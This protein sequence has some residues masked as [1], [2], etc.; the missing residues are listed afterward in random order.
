MAESNPWLIDH[1]RR[2]AAE[3]QQEQGEYSAGAAA[4]T[5]SVA[6]AKGLGAVEVARPAA[7]PSRAVPATET[8]EWAREAAQ[9]A[10]RRSAQKP[11]P[12][13]SGGV[14]TRPSA[15]VADAIKSRMEQFVNDTVMNELSSM[16]GDDGRT[17][18]RLALGRAPA[19]Q[20][21]ARRADQASLRRRLSRRSSCA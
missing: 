20:P 16:R 6:A 19:P 13:Q 8:H 10:A 14:D 11:A 17:L 12:V 21:D 4:M 1:A 15:S 9:V 5:P 18:R 2:V 3:Q 7:Q